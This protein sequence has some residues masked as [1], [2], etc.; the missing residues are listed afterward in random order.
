M[1]F[2]EKKVTTFFLPRNVQTLVLDLSNGKNTRYKNELQITFILFPVLA[3]IGVLIVKP[4]C[5]VYEIPRI[6]YK[7]I[8]HI[9]EQL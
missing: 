4:P 6:K 2:N 3:E 7:I 5:L 1:I 9:F 8:L